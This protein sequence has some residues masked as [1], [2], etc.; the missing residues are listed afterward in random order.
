MSS[1][2]TEP[3]A[4][5]GILP[6]RR[7]SVLQ[8]VPPRRQPQSADQ[9]MMYAWSIGT[10]RAANPGAERPSGQP[11]AQRAPEQ[12]PPEVYIG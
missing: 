8:M 4:V 5:R 1:I 12:C 7:E 9:S 11:T 6:L 3:A 10:T 2:Q